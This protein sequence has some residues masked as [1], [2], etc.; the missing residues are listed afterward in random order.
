MK[1]SLIAAVSNNNVIGK[2]NGLPWKL[3]ADMKLFKATTTGHHVIMGRKTFESFG[4]KPLPNRTNI[5][6]SRNP[7]YNPEGVHVSRGLFFA[8]SRAHD[9]LEFQEPEREIFVIG[10]GEIYQD[11][12]KFA[13]KLYISHVD[14]DIEGDT[15][16]SPIDPQVW[17]LTSA[18]QYRADEK[19]DHDFKFCIYEK[20]PVEK[21]DG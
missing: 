11:A 3:S 14:V 7:E 15:F 2:D 16:F 9:D 1:I 18:V 4:A 21:T 13:N 8:L 19:N 17:T 12:M 10:G 6:I 20:Q 5:V